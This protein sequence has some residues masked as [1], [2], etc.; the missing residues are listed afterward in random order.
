SVRSL[1]SLSETA[2]R[3]A[4]APMLI[5]GAK[6]ATRPSRVAVQPKGSRL[7]REHRTERL[8][9]KQVHM[10]VRY[11]LSAVCSQIGEQPVTGLHQSLLTRHVADRA[12]EP[13][14]LL[15]RSVRRKI[16]PSDVS[17]LGYYQHVDG[18]LRSDIVKSER[19]LI[20]VD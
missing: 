8:T 7:T 14:D 2:S 13:G 20:L 3:V 19:P 9:S 6:G 11:F 1:R 15:G 4:T 17:A 18:R 10:E 16:V 5:I 12:N